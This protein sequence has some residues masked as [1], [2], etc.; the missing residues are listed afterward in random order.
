MIALRKYWRLQHNIFDT[1][2]LELNE[3][4]TFLIV[5][6]E[7][8]HSANCLR[9]PRTI[10][11]RV[12]EMK[13]VGPLYLLRLVSLLQPELF[14]C[15]RYLGSEHQADLLAA[16]H[17]ADSPGWFLAGQ[18]VIPSPLLF[19]ITTNMNDCHFL[20]LNIIIWESLEIFQA[21]YFWISWCLRW[22]LL[23]TQF[24][25]VLL[26][27]S[28]IPLSYNVWNFQVLWHW[29]AFLI[30]CTTYDYTCLCS[31][32]VSLWSMLWQ[33]SEFSPQKYFPEISLLLKYSFFRTPDTNYSSS[34]WPYVPQVT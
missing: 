25:F 16:I 28:M 5:A 7:S 15:P 32:T 9:G 18:L 14:T 19:S 1:H 4:G 6:T 22:F 31:E 10:H 26:F 2:A 11:Y 21:V 3:T 33:D 27:S 34:Y 17:G 24:C 20:F 29:I 23:L 8:L 30:I 12:K 13:I